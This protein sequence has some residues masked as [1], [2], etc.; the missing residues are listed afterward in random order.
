M[1]PLDVVSMSPHSYFP[2]ND[3]LFEET[4]D[5]GSAASWCCE[6]VHRGKLGRR[7]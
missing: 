6:S 5:H 3:Y 7:C 2:M 1:Y 4:Y